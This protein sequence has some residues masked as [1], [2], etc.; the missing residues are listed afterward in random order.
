ML[1]TRPHTIKK[2]E[3]KLGWLHLAY[4]LPSKQAVEGKMEGRIQVTGILSRR[5]KQLLD[6]LK[7]TRKHL[8]FKDKAKA[9]KLWRTGFGR[10]Y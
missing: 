1:T 5:R 2:N 3:G 6:D 10:G 4:E 8:K 9:R 7:E